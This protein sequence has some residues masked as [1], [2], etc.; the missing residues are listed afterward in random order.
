[1]KDADRVCMHK[2]DTFRSEDPGKQI[3]DQTNF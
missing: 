1:M 2:Y 3:Y